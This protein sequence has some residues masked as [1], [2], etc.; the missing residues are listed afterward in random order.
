MGCAFSGGNTI[1]PF[2]LTAFASAFSAFF[3]DG[4]EV[5][6]D[7]G[8]GDDEGVAAGELEGLAVGLGD[9]AGAAEADSSCAVAVK[10][11]CD[12]AVEIVRSKRTESSNPLIMIDDSCASKR[13]SP[14]C[15]VK[16][17]EKPVQSSNAR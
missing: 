12:L 15:E 5:A 14:A 6:A 16:P 4:D 17:F 2:A 10:K 9:G 13:S 3:G 1:L 11:G 7:D 8:A